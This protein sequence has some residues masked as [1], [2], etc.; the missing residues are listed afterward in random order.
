MTFKHMKVETLKRSHARAVEQLENSIGTQSEETTA[1]LRSRT[2]M[3]DGYPIHCTLAELCEEVRKVHR[4]VKFAV[5]GNLKSTWVFGNPVMCEVWAYFEGDAYAFMRLGHADYS[6]RNGDGNKFGVYS[7]LIRNQ[8]YGE[9]R[10]QHHMAMADTVARA[11]K[12][13]KAYTRRYQPKEIAAMSIGDFQS[14]VSSAGWDASAKHHQSVKDVI[15]H[16]SFMGEMRAL[17]ASDHQFNDPLFK[18]VVRKMVEADDELN[19]QADVQHH[20]YWV[21]AREYAGEQVFD[22]ITVFDVKR[23]RGSGVGDHRTYKGE[24]LDT[25]DENLASRMATLSMLDDN[26]FVEGLGMKLSPTMYWVLK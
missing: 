2:R 1:A 20:G 7:R 16:L 21:Q 26:T 22:V 14:K 15:H 23:V 13:V 11:I 19:A 4:D 18:E 17:I 6:I 12:N 10:E 25:V 9:D 5:H 24:E 8:K 3:V